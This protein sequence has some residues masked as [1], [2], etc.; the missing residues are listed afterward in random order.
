MF[1]LF[2]SSLSSKASDWELQPPTL[3][4]LSLPSSSSSSLSD[5]AVVSSDFKS[6]FEE[7]E[8]RELRGLEGEWV[9]E[10]EELEREEDGVLWA[11]LVL[12][13]VETGVEGEDW[14]LLRDGEVYAEEVEDLDLR[15]EEEE[16]LFELDD[17]TGLIGWWDWVCEIESEGKWDLVDNAL[18]DGIFEGENLTCWFP[19]GRIGWVASLGRW[20]RKGRR[21]QEMQREIELLLVDWD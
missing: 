16:E 2:E 19:F 9:L 8:R 6:N 5:G 1:S 14:V 12:A 4:L 7:V 11:A 15:E 3:F 18:V 20:S 21:L 17:F 10:E 13:L